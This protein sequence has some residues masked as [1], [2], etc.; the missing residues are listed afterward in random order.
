MLQKLKRRI[1]VHRKRLIILRVC[2]SMKHASLSRQTV[3]LLPFCFCTCNQDLFCTKTCLV[4]FVKP[5]PLF[6]LK[7]VLYSYCLTTQISHVCS[8]PWFVSEDAPQ[9]VFIWWGI[10]AMKYINQ[11]EHSDLDM[12]L[13][14]QSMCFVPILF[15]I[16]LYFQGFSRKKV[17]FQFRKILVTCHTHKLQKVETSD[18]LLTTGKK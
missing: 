10:V 14:V 2:S 9:F 16:T 5:F 1:L 17:K 7:S 6:K 12:I 3:A 8:P 13:A 15:K 11:N 4:L 18:S